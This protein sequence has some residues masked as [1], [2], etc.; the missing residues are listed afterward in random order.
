MRHRLS[1]RLL[2]T[3]RGRDRRRRVQIRARAFKGMRGFADP[4]IV[5]PAQRGSDGGKFP[6]PP[7]SNERIHQL[8]VQSVRRPPNNSS[9]ASQSTGVCNCSE[10]LSDPPILAMGSC[11]FSEPTEASRRCARN[12]AGRT[13]VQQKAIQRCG[14]RGPV[15]WLAE[16]IVHAGVAALF[17]VALH[18]MRGQRYDR[19]VAAL[20]SSS[21]ANRARRLIAIHRG[22][23]ANPSR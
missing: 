3:A 15:D 7:V 22:H 12:A 9:S 20:P 21:F 5:A 18:G 2:R 23:L 14:E 8:A 10:A 16:V 19:N 17:R 6:T 1:L 11:P 4:C 13:R